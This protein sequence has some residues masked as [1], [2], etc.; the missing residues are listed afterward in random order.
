MT[1]YGKTTDIIQ[2]ELHPAELQNHERHCYRPKAPGSV[3][4]GLQRTLRKKTADGGKARATGLGAR[5]LSQDTLNVYP[6]LVPGGHRGG[7]A[8]KRGGVHPHHPQ[9]ISFRDPA[10]SQHDVGGAQGLLHRPNG[11]A[12]TDGGGT[13]VG[14]DV[15]GCC[16]NCRHGEWNSRSTTFCLL[17][18]RVHGNSYYCLYHGMRGKALDEERKGGDA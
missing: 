11:A 4:H 8:E 6:G 2:A 18:K 15:T 7:R 10:P 1:H 12:N 13:E 9:S 16:G 5:P 3:Q 17:F 14:Q